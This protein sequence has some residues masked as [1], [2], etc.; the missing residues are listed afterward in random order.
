MIKMDTSGTEL[1]VKDGLGNY[2]GGINQFS[3]LEAGS[4][5]L[6]YNECW[7]IAPTYDTDLTTHN[8]YILACGTGIEGCN[9]V[10]TKSISLYRECVSDPR[11]NWRALTIATDLDG[12]RVW[13][14]MDNF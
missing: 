5:E 10:F 12:E 9:W 11:T 3:G 13:S 8:G 14:R 7:G 2:A 6:V 4:D 1:W